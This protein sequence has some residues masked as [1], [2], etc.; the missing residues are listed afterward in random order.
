[1]TTSTST[2]TPPTSGALPPFTRSV[3]AGTGLFAAVLL[4]AAACSSSSSSDSSSSSSSPSPDAPEPAQTAAAEAEACTQ[5]GRVLELGFYAFFAPVSHSADEAPDSAGFN[6]HLGYEADLLTALEAMQGAGL[7][8]S[9]TPIGAWDG[10]WLKSA[11]PEFDVVGGGITVLESRT[12]DAAG[13][14]AV[15]FTSGHIAFRQSL[16]VRAEDEQRL[17]G[18]DELTD[19]V[20]VGV[21]AGTTGEARML[22]LTGLA[23]ADGVLAAGT[24]IDTPQGEV[25]ADGTADYSITA[26]GASPNLQDRRGV[27]PPSEIL[28]QVVYLGSELGEAELLEALGDGR[29]D[30]V[31]R[32]EI[33]NIDAAH[34][35]GGAFAVTALDSATEQ[36][37]FTLSAD[38]AEL[39]SC[40]DEKIDY[41]TD[42][43]RIGYSEWREDPSVFM[44]RAE[45]WDIS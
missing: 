29:I 19:D 11:G 30:A 34:G 37:G 22:V 23:D 9:R 17:A 14:K 26:S 15:A 5:G 24:R 38:D 33:G 41:L 12:L 13:E 10:I 32:G 20:R 2:R 1:M 35:S 4:V 28:P 36:G 27:Q 8:F 21:V 6:T 39:M 3:R 16:L 7:S 25:V 45:A 43:R 18:H 44:R 42:D 40:L 31:A